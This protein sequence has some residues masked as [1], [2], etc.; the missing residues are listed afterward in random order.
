[1][2]TR[3]SNGVPGPAESIKHT[4]TLYFD[5]APDKYKTAKT[6]MASANALAILVYTS[7]LQFIL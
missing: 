2:Q 5:T 6:S 1:M 4:H 3:A 7:K